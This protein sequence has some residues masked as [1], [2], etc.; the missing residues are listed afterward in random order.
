[1][2]NKLRRAQGVHSTNIPEAFRQYGLYQAAN[3]TFYNQLLTKLGEW[4]KVKNLNR[5]EQHSTAQNSTAH[6]PDPLRRRYFV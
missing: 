5:T 6:N 4:A 3:V 1:V 2:N